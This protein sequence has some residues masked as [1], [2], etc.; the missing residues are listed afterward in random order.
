MVTAHRR[1]ELT[2][3]ASP[4]IILL[5]VQQTEPPRLH[6]RYQ[7]LEI[8]MLIEKKITHHCHY[9]KNNLKYSYTCS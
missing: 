1:S 6:V 3:G 8:P 4:S 9:E 7:G 2:D 5:F